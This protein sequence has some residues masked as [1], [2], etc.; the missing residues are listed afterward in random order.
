MLGKVPGAW[1]THQA[2]GLLQ[3]NTREKRETKW[4][5]N[6][7][8]RLHQSL[9]P[10]LL[11]QPLP[12]APRTRG[13]R[14]GRAA[15]NPHREPGGT[16]APSC[17]RV[18]PA[19]PQARPSEARARAFC[20]TA[21]AGAHSRDRARRNGK[22]PQGRPAPPRRHPCCAP[23]AGTCPAWHR[24]WA[25]WQ[26]R[27]R[28]PSRLGGCSA[29]TPDARGRGTPAGGPAQGAGS[30]GRDRGRGTEPS[31]PR[32]AP[33]YLCAG[34]VMPRGCP[35]SALPCPARARPA[36]GRSP[37]PPRAHSLGAAGHAP[38][39]A[40]RLRALPLAAPRPASKRP[41]RA[42]VR[43]G[44]RPRSYLLLKGAAAASGSSGEGQRHPLL[45]RGWLRGS[46]AA[47]AGGIRP[48]PCTL[49]PSHRVRARHTICNHHT[50][51]APVTPSCR[52]PS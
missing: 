1:R 39:P 5:G 41:P 6:F 47:A 52:A 27:C 17:R 35:R 36:A 34:A 18:R 43:G 8:D 21:A 9:A 46:P 31:P 7:P 48:R 45:P 42:Q 14:G 10:L 33:T 37:A 24:S 20:R 23:R 40:S 25:P 15:A 32:A 49:H 16:R 30:R 28:R 29:A 19:A 50:V 11:H 13:G 12:S 22:K 44:A 51:C 3:H 38:A 26:G 2:P 4:G